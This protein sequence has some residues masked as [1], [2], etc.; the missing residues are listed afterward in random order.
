M[1]P[2]PPVILLLFALGVGLG[3]CAGVADQLLGTNLVQVSEGRRLAQQ[4][5][6]SC[7]AIKAAGPSPAA[8]ARSFGEIAQRHRGRS[9]DWQLETI[10]EA[11][12]FSMPAIA[13]S[14]A[15]QASLAAYIR[16]QRP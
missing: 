7:H 4:R 11:G 1:A 12:H 3:G 15:E 14:P 6:A 13:L 9:L 10:N 16:R 2:R 5:C 8:E